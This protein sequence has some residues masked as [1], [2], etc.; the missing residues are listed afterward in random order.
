MLHGT[1]SAPP[2]GLAQTTPQNSPESYSVMSEPNDVANVLQGLGNSADEVATALK[3]AGTRGVRN[4]VR[5]LNPI[6]RFVEAQVRDTWNLNIISG[7]TLSMNFRSGGK[8]KVALP[9]AVKQFLHAFNHG[10]YAELEL[11][12]EH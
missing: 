6:V 4:T 3:V 12:I 2:S 5:L 11:P 10:A 1:Q 7:D 9:E 8:G